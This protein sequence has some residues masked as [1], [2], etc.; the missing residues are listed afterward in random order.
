MAAANVN[1]HVFK[2]KHPLPNFF[3]PLCLFKDLLA[4]D[5]MHPLAKQTTHPALLLIASPLTD[6]LPRWHLRLSGH[7]DRVFVRYVLEGLEHGFHVGFAH[8][9]TL[10]A[11][12]SNM[13]SARLHPAV[14]SSYLSEEVDGRRMSGPFLPGQIT[15]LHINRMGVVP[16][17]HTPGRWR[18]ITDLSHPEG[19]SVKNGIEAQLCSLKYTSV[20]SVAI[21]AQR[22]GRGALLAKLD[23]RSAYRLVPVHP[24]PAGGGVGG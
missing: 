6:C 4:L 23:I 15:G 11:A 12:P 3:R 10:H 19:V 14:I 1:N 16:K 18:L 21:A 20:E 24:L 17:G 7:P 8:S 2:H 13:Q 22:L 9:S 5:E